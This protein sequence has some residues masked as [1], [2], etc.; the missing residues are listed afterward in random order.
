MGLLIKLLVTFKGIGMINFL[1]N[2]FRVIWKAI[3]EVNK[4]R[5]LWVFYMLSQQNKLKQ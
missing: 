2:V 1:K 3:Y 4:V 5:R